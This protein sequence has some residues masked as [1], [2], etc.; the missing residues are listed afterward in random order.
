MHVALLAPISWRTPPRHYGPWERVCSL[1]AEGL[2]ARGVEV[3]LFATADSQ[4]RG[5][6]EAVCPRPY[7]EDE[8]LDPKVWEGLHIGHCFEQAESFDLIHNH[9]DFLPLTYTGLTTTPV[10]TTIHGFSSER[11]LP[12]YQRYDGRVHYVAIS[13]ADRHPSL[14]YAATIHHGIDLAAYHLRREPGDYLLCYGRIHPDKGTADAIRIAEAAGLPLVIAGPIHDRA[15]YEAEVAPRV[16]GERVRYLGSVGP[17]EGDRL[18]GGALCLLHP[19]RFEEPF[20]L[21]V[22]EAGAC[23]TPV[24]AYPRGALPELVAE[25]VSG[26]LVADEAAAVEAVGRVRELDREA[27]RRHVEAHFSADRM[28]DDYLALYERIVRAAAREDHRPWGSYHVYADRPDHKVK[29]IEVLPGKRLSLQLHH[30]RREHW[31][32]VSGRGIV[33]RDD[34]RI[35]IGPGDSVDIPQGARHRIENP[36]DELLVFVE[37]QLGDYFGEDDIVRLEDDFGRAG[38]TTPDGR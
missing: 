16:D 23:G 19:V 2:V 14:T 7:S 21:A 11:I 1:L 24:V 3:T 27:C 36:G 31:L 12:A 29:R 8:G 34:E 30:R 25:G 37:V 32:V 38:T 20:G 4:T 6:L 18:L 26:F 33:T 28:V 17:E 15:Y 22:V 35:E 10:V 13:E 9:F 5:R